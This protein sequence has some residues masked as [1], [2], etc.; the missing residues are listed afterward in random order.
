M[1]NK[2]VTDYL[3][4]KFSSLSYSKQEGKMFAD[5]SYG[6]D[7]MF[8]L[9]RFITRFSENGI[10]DKA[11]NIDKAKE[12]VI[13]IFNLDPN[14]AGVVNYL[15][16]A[17]SLLCFC[18]A[19]S[20][21]QGAMKYK[22]LDQNILDIYCSNMENAY[23]A[24]YMLAYCVF[25]HD[26]IWEFFKEFA[27]ARDKES[28]QNAYDKIKKAILAN[29]SNIEKWCNF[30]AKFSTNILGFANKTRMVARTGNVKNNILNI[31]DV[32]INVAGTRSGVHKLKKNTYLDDLSNDYILQTLSPYLIILPEQVGKIVLSDG[33]AADIADTKMDM[34]DKEKLT[35]E[36]KRQIKANKYTVALTKIRTVQDEFRKTLLLDIPHKCPICGFNFEKMLTASHIMP[37]SR[38]T[39][40]EDAINPGNGL[41]MCPVCDRLFESEGGLYI[42][43]DKSDGH[44]RY[45]D[46]IKDNKWLNYVDGVKIEKSYLTDD[47]KKYLEWH[48]DQFMRKH[49][50][51]IIHG[52]SSYSYPLNKNYAEIETTNWIVAEAEP[53]R[54]DD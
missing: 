33:F 8:F 28:Q 44:I 50:H 20:K 34:L 19:L 17:L 29:A 16:E 48:N 26:G 4:N 42:T 14:N 38:C 52:D 3:V 43:I 13:D 23:I 27:I 21:E 49:E 10:F 30:V 40:T 6:F 39:N 22:V 9:C 2:K 24:Q 32:A 47:R 15:S 41:L 37:Y 7:T 18:G 35:E 31:K 11:K 46:E 36:G 54:E 45:V 25:N 51:D 12:Y 1:I 53:T 5:K